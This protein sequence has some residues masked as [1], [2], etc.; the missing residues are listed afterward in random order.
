MGPAGETA[1]LVNV[2]AEALAQREVCRAVDKAEQL[3]IA[4]TPVAPPFNRKL[5]VD[6]V[7]SGDVAAP[8]T[9]DAF[10]EPSLSTPVR[11]KKPQDVREVLWSSRIAI[12]GKPECFPTD[13][14]GGWGNG[15]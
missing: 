4:G 3:P 2:V 1:G 6:L 7:F 10:S 8:R 15:N 5:Q 9:I 12:F 14:G 13:K 11:P